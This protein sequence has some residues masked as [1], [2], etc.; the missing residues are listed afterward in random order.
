MGAAW[1][2]DQGSRAAWPLADHDLP[3]CIAPRSRH[4][5]WLLDGPIN[6]ESFRVYV[7]DV[8]VPTLRPGDIVIMDNLGSHRSQ[9][10]RQAIRATGARLLFLPKYSPDLNPIEQ[11]FSKLKHWLRKA[12]KRSTNTVCDAIGEIL[13]TVSTTECS[14]YFANAGYEQT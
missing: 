5:P 11:F 7:E 2:T 8:L 1:P 13:K 10:V 12:A 4:R 6:G 9:A 14:N 3:S